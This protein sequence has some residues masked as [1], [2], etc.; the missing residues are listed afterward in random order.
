MYINYSKTQSSGKIPSKL[1]KEAVRENVKGYMFTRFFDLVKNYDKVLEKNFPSAMHVY[2]VFFEGVRDFYK[3]MKQYLKITRI[4]KTSTN[5]LMALT[6]KELELYSRM[7]RDM[8]KIAP[9]LFLTSLPLVGYAVF[10]LAYVFQLEFSLFFEF[11]LK[12]FLNF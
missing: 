7:P 1:S 9:T 3:D 6:R 5:G 11:S 10:P 8:I 4:V 2:R 12:N